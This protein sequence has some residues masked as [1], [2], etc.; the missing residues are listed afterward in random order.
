MRISYGDKSFLFTGDIGADAEE[1]LLSGKVLT[2]TVLK[3]PHHGSR[4][5]STPAFLNAVRPSYVVVSVGRNN[6]FGFPNAESLENYER[7][8]AKVLRTDLNGAVEMTTDGKG[9]HVAAYG[10]GL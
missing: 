2:S 1:A 7:A 10:D 8:G 6:P 4:R 3:A 9:L 5:S